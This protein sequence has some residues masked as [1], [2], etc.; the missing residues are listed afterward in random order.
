MN[1]CETV[2]GGWQIQVRGAERGKRVLQMAYMWLVK[3][4]TDVAPSP[5]PVPYSP[6]P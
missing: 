1:D 3:N 5:A 2:V 6:V 4:F